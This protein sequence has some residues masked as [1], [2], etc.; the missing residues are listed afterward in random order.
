MTRKPPCPQCMVQ[1]VR[2]GVSLQRPLT[3]GQGTPPSPR[4]PC[5][6]GSRTHSSTDRVTCPHASSVPTFWLEVPVCPRSRTCLPLRKQSSGGRF[7]CPP[8]E[9]PLLRAHGEDL[10]E[11]EAHLCPR[12]HLTDAAASQAHGSS[13]TQLVTES[14]PP[15]WPWG[16]RGQRASMLLPSG[17]PAGR[18]TAAPTHAHAR[19]M[20]P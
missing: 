5:L 8:W 16:G 19:C 4:L 13:L 10:Q 18:Q 17:P 6:H 3:R 2:R 14:R 7:L 12:E 20:M 9:A 15:M 11:A 1:P